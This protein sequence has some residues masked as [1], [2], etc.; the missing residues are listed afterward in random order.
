MSTIIGDPC[1]TAPAFTFSSR[2]ELEVGAMCGHW[3]LRK[4]TNT[5]TL[6]GNIDR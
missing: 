1:K 4:G 3:D 6:T 5:W 2:W